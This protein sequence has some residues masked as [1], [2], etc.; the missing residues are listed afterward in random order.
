[1]DGAMRV[2]VETIENTLAWLDGCRKATDHLRQKG[3][4]NTAI[5]E[6]IRT[7][8]QEWGNDDLGQDTLSEVIHFLEGYRETIVGLEDELRGAVNTVCDMCNIVDDSVGFSG[9]AHEEH[10]A[11][12]IC[13]FCDIDGSNYNGWCHE[14]GEEGVVG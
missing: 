4:D 10:K 8:E 6:I 13:E 2:R 14:A 12:K 11:I 7:V 5:D 3:E 1:M 9:C